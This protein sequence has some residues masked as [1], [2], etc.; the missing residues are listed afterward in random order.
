LVLLRPV[1]SLWLSVVESGAAPRPINNGI[2]EVLTT[3]LPSSQRSTAA[4]SPTFAHTSS[5]PSQQSKQHSPPQSKLPL[6]SGGLPGRATS[7]N[8]A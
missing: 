6:A 7:S 2:T 8:E 1:A 4:G 5:A 3:E